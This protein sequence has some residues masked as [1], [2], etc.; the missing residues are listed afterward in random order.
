MIHNLKLLA[1]SPGRVIQCKCC[2]VVV[3]DLI[4]LKFNGIFVL[5]GVM[6]VWLGVM[7]KLHSH[8]APG[9]TN[10]SAA[11]PVKQSIPHITIIKT[12]T[13]P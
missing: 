2:R 6:K 9:A 12:Y 5:V 13:E 4:R 3:V 10:P 1:L 7:C 11:L 8:E